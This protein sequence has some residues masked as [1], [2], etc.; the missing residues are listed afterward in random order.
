MAITVIEE[1]KTQKYLVM[2]FF[3]LVVGIAFILLS[4]FVKREEVV[5]PSVLPPKP[6]ARIEIKFQVLRNPVLDQLS[7][8]F[9]ELP[10][11][12]TEPEN[13][14]RIIGRQNPFAPISAPIEVGE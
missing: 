7:E 13:I 2:L 9:P 1:R 11:L 3:V 8:P 12:P 4:K 6:P 5:V 10:S 14:S